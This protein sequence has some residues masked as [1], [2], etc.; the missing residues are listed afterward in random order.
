[1]IAT[2]QLQSDT[3]VSFDLTAP[4]DKS[5]NAKS[6]RAEAQRAQLNDQMRGLVKRFSAPQREMS[7]Y[8]G[9][10]HT[11]SPNRWVESPTLIDDAIQFG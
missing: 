4:E 2:T 10:R 3:L 11:L 8:Y 5:E 9:H 1:M 7:L 6:W